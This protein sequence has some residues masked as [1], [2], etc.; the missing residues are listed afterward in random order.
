MSENAVMNELADLKGQV[1]RR[2]KYTTIEN[3]FL[4]NPSYTPVEKAVFNS[5]CT[6]A[7]GKGICFPGQST[8]AKNL[9]IT[10][11][12]VNSAIKT[13]TEKGGLLV[14]KQITESN[15]KTV[16]TYFLADIDQTTGNFIPE[17]L[18]IYRELVKEPKTVQGK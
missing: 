9:G 2:I 12:T 13:L 8:L 14:L 4:N 7:Y 10:R 11:Q 3:S 15:R 17:S 18:D 6:Y 16:N 5:L 1:V